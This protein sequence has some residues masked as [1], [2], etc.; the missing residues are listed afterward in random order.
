M[1]K[2]SDADAKVEQILMHEPDDFFYKAVPST[3][4]YLKKAVMLASTYKDPLLT[5]S[6]PGRA[7]NGCWSPDFSNLP[8]NYFYPNTTREDVFKALGL[9]IDGMHDLCQE[10]IDNISDYLLVRVFEYL[11]HQRSGCLVPAD[12]SCLKLLDRQFQPLAGIHNFY[13]EQVHY[14]LGVLIGAYIGSCVDSDYWRT[15]TEEE[16]GIDM[17]KGVCRAVHLQNLKELGLTLNDLSRLGSTR[18]FTLEQLVESGAVSDANV[19]LFKDGYASGFVELKAGSGISDDAALLALALKFGKQ[20]TKMGRAVAC[21]FLLMDSDDTWDKSTARIYKGGQDENIG[22]RI[23]EQYEIKFGKGS[24][25]CTDKDITAII[26][27]SAINGAD[28]C[29][30]SC[31]QRRFVQMDTVTGFSALDSHL[32]WIAAVQEGS[33]VLPSIPI[34][35]QQGQSHALYKTLGD[36]YSEQAAKNPLIPAYAF[37]VLGGSNGNRNGHAGNGGNG[38]NGHKR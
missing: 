31:S 27:L 10:V 38:R 17:H 13:A 22:Q 4:A 16:Y 32:A 7:A 26:Y 14:P 25:P 19:N 24:F 30:P 8:V 11:D 34:G 37:P 9:D 6:M 29:F 23:H 36:R 21:G 20:D 35:F 1:Q 2:S 15:K 3:F 18:L 28:G 12:I 33:P 5:F